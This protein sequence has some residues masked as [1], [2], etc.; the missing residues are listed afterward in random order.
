MS[1]NIGNPTI[2]KKFGYFSKFFGDPNGLYSRIGRYPGMVAEGQRT[3]YAGV[4]FYNG[5]AAYDAIFQKNIAL[6][7]DS[8]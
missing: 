6:N 1:E 3:A 5:I 8:S 2:I 7:G 4:M